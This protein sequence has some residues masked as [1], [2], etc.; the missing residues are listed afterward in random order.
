[1]SENPFE[2]P[3]HPCSHESTPLSV[4]EGSRRSGRVAQWDSL[5]R[6][7]DTLTIG[8]YSVRLS[9]YR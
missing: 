5:S 1:M 7:W 3:M 2:Y 6:Q 9:H 8:H 4:R